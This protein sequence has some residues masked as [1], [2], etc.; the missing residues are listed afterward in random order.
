[1]TI[2]VSEAAKRLGV[3]N[4]TIKRRI[5][6]G[7]LKAEKVGTAWVIDE[8]AIK[9]SWVRFPGVGSTVRASVC[10]SPNVTVEYIKIPKIDFMPVDFCWK[11]F[12]GTLQDGTRIFDNGFKHDELI[13]IT[14]GD[15]VLPA[16]FDKKGN[17]GIYELPPYSPNDFKYSEFKAVAWAKW[18]EVPKEIK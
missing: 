14:N 16:I 18:L 12:I 15:M 6:K 11:K 7:E 5:Y 3:S 13:F 1:M 8:E 10:D 17:G 4:D 9:N 2:T